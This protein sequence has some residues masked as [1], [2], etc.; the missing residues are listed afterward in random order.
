[1]NVPVQAQCKF[2]RISV[3]GR[4]FQWPS[5]SENPLSI[6]VAA[7]MFQAFQVVHDYL[8]SNDQ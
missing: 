5:K 4:H 6:A 8:Q 1:M 2:P 3:R 7:E